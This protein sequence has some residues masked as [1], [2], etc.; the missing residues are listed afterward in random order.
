MI[1]HI[2]CNLFGHKPEKEYRLEWLASFDPP[3][4]KL[5]C[6]R[7]GELLDERG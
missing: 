4:G 6:K 1:A 7:C 2:I 5:Y 3:I